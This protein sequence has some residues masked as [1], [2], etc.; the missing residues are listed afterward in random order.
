MAQYILAV[1]NFSD[2]KNKDVIEAVV[3]QVRNVEGVKLLDYH[4]DPDFNRTVVTVIG[5]PAELKEALLKMAGKSIELINMEEQSGSHPRIGAQD[6]I[7][8]FPLRN[9]TLGECIQLAE[10]I[11]AEVFKRYNVPVFFTAENS[12][13]PERRSL[14]FIRRGQYEGLKLVA[15]TEARKPDIG[16]A[17]LHPTAGAT[18]VSAGTNPLVAFNVILDTPN[19]DIAQK[20]SKIV[21]ALRRFYHGPFDRANLFRA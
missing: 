2:G 8:I 12:R 10:E 18:I 19:L 15:H 7:P 11:G 6:T 20:I 3:D 9:I 4:P 13:A 1:P 16:P 21:R 17:A 14:D 5:K